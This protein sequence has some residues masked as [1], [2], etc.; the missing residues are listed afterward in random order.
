VPTKLMTKRE[1]AEMRRW[2]MSRSSAAA[3]EYVRLLDSYEAAMEALAGEITGGHT[4]GCA[5]VMYDGRRNCDCPQDL[6]RQYE[7]EGR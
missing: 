7:G 6:V 4:L 1:C 3:E 5:F 2:A